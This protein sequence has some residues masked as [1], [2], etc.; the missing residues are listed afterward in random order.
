MKNCIKVNGKLYAL[1]ALLLGKEPL[2][3]FDWGGLGGPQSL[4]GHFGEE[5]NLLL[6][7]G[8]EPQLSSP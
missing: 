3:L 8:L 4:S 2:L 7:M 6:L 1:A 5:K